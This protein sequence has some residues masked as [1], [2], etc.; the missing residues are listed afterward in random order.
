MILK[1]ERILVMERVVENSLAKLFCHHFYKER[2][3]SYQEIL[4]A[5]FGNRRVE[6]Q[7]KNGRPVPAKKLLHMAIVRFHQL[8]Q[9]LKR[10]DAC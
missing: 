6:R 3:C 10:A 7:L 2:T 1:D 4:P 8:L 9:H 5:V